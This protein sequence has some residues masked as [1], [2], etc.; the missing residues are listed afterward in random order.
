MNKYLKAEQV[1]A[2]L[3]DAEDPYYPEEVLL[4]AETQVSRQ[5][6]LHVLRLPGKPVPTWHRSLA[7]AFE[8]AELAGYDEL[9][10]VLA[11]RHYRVSFIQLED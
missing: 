6:S 7:Q 9:T 3:D 1:N 10:I 2:V 11:E 8:A 5:Y 4:F